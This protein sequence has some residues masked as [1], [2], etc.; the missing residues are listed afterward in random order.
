[1]ENSQLLGKQIKKLRNKAGLTQ[2]AL[3]EKIGVTSQ[4]IIYLEKGKRNPRIGLLY[5]MAESLDVK[6]G[7]FFTF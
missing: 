2:E 5:K 6:V 4:Y 1:M 7:D 3:A